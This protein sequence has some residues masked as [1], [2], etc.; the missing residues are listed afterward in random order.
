M[1]GR[2]GW[3]VPFPSTSFA[4]VSTL[5]FQF[6]LLPILKLFYSSFSLLISPFYIFDSFAE[7]IGLVLPPLMGLLNPLLTRREEL[8]FARWEPCKQHSP[9]SSENLTRSNFQQ[10][11]ISNCERA[12]ANM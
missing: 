7:I 12:D 11:S 2:R 9:P 6:P 10:L 8:T 5:R 4:K 3:Y 1:V